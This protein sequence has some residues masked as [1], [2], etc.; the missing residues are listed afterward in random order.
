LRFSDALLAASMVL[1]IAPC[2]ATAATPA[3]DCLEAAAVAE[4][5][6][7]LP[8]GL[9]A[10]IG[11]YHS[12]SPAEAAPYR[13]RVLHAWIVRRQPYPLELAAPAA[14]DALGTPVAPGSG[15]TG[16]EDHA[17]PVYTAL[18]LPD[19]LRSILNLRPL[20]PTGVQRR[21]SRS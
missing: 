10:A 19:G 12:A 1:L 14:R 21:L 5:R 6:W 7:G 20:V 8:E 17:I 3:L 16:S 9:L 15:A 2:V 4:R 13:Q 18:T 11:A